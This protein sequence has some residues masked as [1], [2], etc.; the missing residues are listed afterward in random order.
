M[1]DPGEYSDSPSKTQ[2]GNYRIDSADND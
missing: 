1:N 2:K